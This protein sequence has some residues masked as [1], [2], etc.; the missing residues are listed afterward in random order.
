MIQFLGQGQVGELNPASDKDYVCI[1]D[2]ASNKWYILRYAMWSP[3]P[4]YE[5]AVY[6]ATLNGI[7]PDTTYTDINDA[8]KRV[9]RTNKHVFWFDGRANPPRTWFPLVVY[10]ENYGTVLFWKQ[11]TS[12]PENA[13]SDFFCHYDDQYPKVDKPLDVD[14]SG[15]RAPTWSVASTGVA[16]PTPNILKVKEEIDRNAVNLTPTP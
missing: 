6:A 8:L 15:N 5:K 12:Q 2:P 9:H 16:P 13:T 4:I 14:A 7:T 10:R 1:R 11:R 3:Y